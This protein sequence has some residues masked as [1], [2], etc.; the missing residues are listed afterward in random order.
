MACRIATRIH[1][2]ASCRPE[3]TQLFLCFIFSVVFF[4]FFVKGPPASSHHY[5]G[6]HFDT[7]T[8]GL[9]ICTNDSPLFDGRD[10]GTAVE[11]A[12]AWNRSWNGGVIISDDL[13]YE[14]IHCITDIDG[15]TRER[16]KVWRFRAGTTMYMGSGE[17]Y[18]PCYVFSTEVSMVYREFR[19][20]AGRFRDR[21]TPL[22]TRPL[23][24]CVILSRY[25]LLAWG[26]G[27]DRGQKDMA[28]LALGWKDWALPSEDIPYI[29]WGCLT[30]IHLIRIFS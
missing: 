24:V 17:G 4:F 10:F 13:A 23:P 25:I 28:W 21:G 8:F 22:Y 18:L 15:S 14:S 9:G 19:S 5:S 30:T 11:R 7:H 29:D 26:R 12:F 3:T 1:F 2:S 27:G 6:F 20:R 16:W